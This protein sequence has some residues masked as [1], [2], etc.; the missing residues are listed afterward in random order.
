MDDPIIDADTASCRQ[1]AIDP[2]G[3]EAAERDMIV[4]DVRETDAGGADCVGKLARVQHVGFGEP[5]LASNVTAVS[6]RLRR[7]IR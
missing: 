6:T 3:Q 4:A 5:V 1:Q 7:R 2:A